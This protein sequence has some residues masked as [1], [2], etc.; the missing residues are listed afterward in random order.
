L[1]RARAAGG[2]GSATYL[3]H[4]TQDELI[5]LM[6]A[7]VRKSLVAE[8]KKAKYYAIMVDSTPDIAHIDQFAIV[9][10]YV[11]A[12]PTAEPVIRTAFLG[13]VQMGKDASSVSAGI[14]EFLAELGIDFKD[15]RGQCYDN[16]TVMTGDIRGVQRQLLDKNPQATFV[17][18]NNHS[19]NLA[20]KDAVNTDV[21]SHNF[22]SHVEDVYHFFASSTGRWELLMKAGIT[23]ARATDT[24]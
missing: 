23:V 5:S 6:A 10:R 7:D 19:L 1:E 2:R 24:R 8:I 22:F 4:H 13:F 15:C 17:N 9:V 3:S 21:G 12:K 16:A 18:C 11:H 14:V 20:G